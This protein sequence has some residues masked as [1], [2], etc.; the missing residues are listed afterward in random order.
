M[1]NKFNTKL[2]LLKYTLFYNFLICALLNECERST[3][4]LKDRECVSTYCSEEQ[5]KSG[6]C[7]INEPITKTQWLTSIIKFENTNGDISLT[8]EQERNYRLLFSTESSDNKEK[9]YFGINIEKSENNLIFENGGKFVSS[10]R[11]SINEGDEMINPKLSFIKKDLKNYYIASIGT[12]NS[13]IG[14]F[15]EKNYTVGYTIIDSADFLNDTDTR[16]EGINSMAI[17][18]SFSDF[19]YSTITTKLDEPTHYNLS[20]YHYIIEIE[21]DK[22]PYFKYNSM[23]VIDSTKGNYSSCFTFYQGSILC[24][25]LSQDNFYTIVVVEFVEGNF[26]IRNKSIVGSPSNTN[27]DNIYFLK[28]FGIGTEKAIFSYFSGDEDNIP[29]FLIKMIGKDYSLSD[30]FEDFPVIYLYDYIFNNNIKYNDVTGVDY[31][32]IFYISTNNNKDILLIAYISIY[33]RTEKKLVIRYYNIKLQEYYYMNILNS[34][35]ITNLAY[36]YL[37]IAFDF[38]NYDLCQDSENNI[39]NAGLIFLSHINH[40]NQEIDF[41]EYAFENNTKYILINFTEGVKLEN[42]I[43]GYSCYLASILDYND[44]SGLIKYYD[45]ADE[46]LDLYIDYLYRFDDIIKAEI[47]INSSVSNEMLFYYQVY[48][49][50]PDNVSI[51]NQYWDRINDTLGSRNDKESNGLS[52]LTSSYIYYYIT[53]KQNLSP[54]CNDENCTLCLEEDKDYCLIC[55]DNNYIV[56]YGDEYKFG[57]LKL[58]IEPKTETTIIEEI[59]STQN[60]VPSTNI[61]IETTLPNSGEST[62]FSKESLSYDISENMETNQITDISKKSSELSLQELLQEK[63]KEVNLSDEQIKKLYNDIRDYIYNDYNG[64]NTIV[65]TANVKIQISSLEAQLQSELS[66]VDLGKCAEILKEKYCKSDNNSLILLKFDITP[67]NSKSAYV[68]YKVY[69]QA[70]KQFLEMKECSGTNVRINSHIDLDSYIETLYDSMAIYGYNLFDP[71]DSFYNDICAAFTTENDTDILLYDRRMDIYEKTINISLCQEGCVFLSYNSETKKKECD[72]PIQVED[73]KTNTFELQ[74]EANDLVEEFYDVLKN[75]NFRIMR[76]YKLP[77]NPKIFIKNIGSILMTIIL[78]IFLSLIIFYLAKKTNYIKFYI[79]SIIK[80]RN[81]ENK[82]DQSNLSN[83]IYYPKINDLNSLVPKSINNSEL[84]KEIKIEPKK[85]KNKNKKMIKKNTLSSINNEISNNTD[86]KNSPPKRKNPNKTEDCFL[87]S[88]NKNSNDQTNDKNNN[89]KFNKYTNIPNP[90]MVNNNEEIKNEDNAIKNN[91][92]PNNQ[93]DNIQ[94]KRDEKNNNNEAK[95]SSLKHK[96]KKKKVKKASLRNKT[97]GK[98]VGFAENSLEK[99]KENDINNIKVYEK[100]E[101]QNI[102]I[103]KLND[104]EMNTLEYEKAL[105]FDKRN[106]FQYYYSLIKKKQLILFTFLPTNDYNIMALK[107]SLFIVSFC[108][109]FT[110]NTFFFSDK[111]MH[112]IYKDNGSFNILYQIPQ[113]FYSSIIPTIINMILKTLSLTEKDVLK[114]K[115]EKDIKMLI[116]ESKKVEKC[117]YIKFVI[118]FSISLLLMLFFWYFISC[119]CAVYNNTQ[120]ILIKDSLISFGISMLYPFG[121]NL[122]PGLFRF[123]ALR[124]EKKDKEC[125]YKISQ[126]IA[127][128]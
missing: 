51:F 98:N 121:L 117:I 22:H 30:M 54:L 34:V 89:Y 2:I 82:E 49:E 103:E 114:L 67:E 78:L 99:K 38:C 35:Q 29:T 39:N 107:I 106:Y 88:E 32:K 102:N 23:N 19:I 80:S 12:K 65:N 127:L 50:I 92:I 60:N 112:K 120:I 21:D 20:L 73:I 36:D 53:I 6:E 72:C 7:L 37:I 81:I 87:D 27:E 79:Q 101:N 115:Q 95:K 45:E 14:L 83:N 58:C 105:Q 69:D 100:I 16:I 28:A 84:I 48:M 76:C 11:K 47:M 40:T 113:I 1:K 13:K 55:K 59:S 85:R 74:F 96:V 91:E 68:Q 123:P 110:I 41:I 71:N 15:P 10:I 94:E 46:L 124:A 97:S 52:M 62:I 93:M 8:V 90:P 31:D 18:Y 128:I 109:Y 70:S 56:L 17:A 4:I 3:P 33:G 25:Y 111:T 122:L 24:F 63:Y 104:Q 44:F 116:N 118:F 9:I 86:H 57:K 66:N 108:L 77:F 42:N 125:L 43:L 61:E 119:F 5:F 126:Y 75:S 26:E 64:E